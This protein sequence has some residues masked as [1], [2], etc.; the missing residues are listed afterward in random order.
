MCTSYFREIILMYICL[1]DWEMIKQILSL[2]EIISAFKIIEVD[3]VSIPSS[4]FPYGPPPTGSDEMSESEAR[5]RAWE[6]GDVDYNGA[7]S[8]DNIMKKLNESMGCTPSYNA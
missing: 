1:F 5:R 7:D 8:F 4:T 2:Q 3:K 6:N